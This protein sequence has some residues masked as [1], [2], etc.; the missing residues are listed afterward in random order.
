MAYRLGVDIGGTFTDLVLIEEGTGR[1]F[2]GKTLTTPREPADG[3]VKG[4]AELLGRHG[5]AAGRIGSVIHAT[6]LVTNALIERKGA[7]TGLLTTRGFRDVLEVG[8]EKRF[9]LYDLF[10]EMPRPLIPRP[11]RLEADERMRLDGTAER[12]L[13]PAS[14]RQAARALAAAGVESVAVSFLHAY[15]NPAHE[16]AAEALLRAEMPGVYA[17]RSSAVAP[18]I[19]EFERTS[20][21]AANAFVQPL[22]DRYLGRLAADL[23]A[24]GC[25]A[26]LTLMLSSGGLCS[27]EDARALPVR[28]VESGPAAGALAAAQV[29]RLAGREAVLGFDM[30][31][32]TAK[33]CLVD[34]GEPVTVFAFEVARTSRFQRG[35]GLPILAPTIELIEIGAGGGSLARIDALGLLKVGPESAGA[36]PGPACYGLGGEHPTVTDADLVLGYLNPDFFL[37]GE[38]RLDRDAAEAAIAAGVGQ[39]LGLDAVRAAWGIFDTVSETMA[40]AARLHIAE[41]GKD[42]R[43]YTL[44]AT[45]GAGPVHA[46]HVARKLQIGQVLCPAAAGVASTLGLLVAPPKADLVRSYV[47]ALA[48]VEWGA[49]NSLYAEM[50]GQARR[51]LDLVGVD[52][53]AVRITRQADMR[54]VGQG[55]EI[56]VPVPGG[57]LGPETRTTLEAS[58]REV[59]YALFGRALEGV[60]IEAINWRVTLAGPAGRLDAVR[61]ERPREEAPPL[62]GTRPGFVAE[63]GGLAPVPVYDRYALPAATRFEGPA[64]VE[65]RESTALI[66]PGASF[67]A[68]AFGNLLIEGLI[69]E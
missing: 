37:G 45:G 6:T 22:A 38:M 62:K 35:S 3:V 63:R 52:P 55:H 10:L 41:K 60:P 14:V 54:Y 33:L 69:R 5:L 26:P 66:P 65:E 44:V 7:R 19:K 25:R 4:L 42:P 31:G 64:I 67:V 59:Y 56:V 51:M 17:S 39:R 15:A 24:L 16:M 40:S 1:A 20:T 43:R 27:A 29:G 21:T 58:F 2:V 8:R 36:D 49:L 47:R 32:T 68:D 13:D 18:E 34:G 30:G 9:D 50:E 11:L 53:G 61:P 57:A 28:L 48:D 23:E 46:A 12:P